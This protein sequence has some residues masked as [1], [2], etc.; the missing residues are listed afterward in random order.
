MPLALNTFV[1]NS[2]PPPPI[3]IHL[4]DFF[5]FNFY[6]FL[7]PINLYVKTRY[8]HNDN[9]EQLTKFNILS[10]NRN[11]TV[12]TYDKGTFTLSELLCKMF[13]IYKC[14]ENFMSSFKLISSGKEILCV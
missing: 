4:F 13:N 12:C 5:H 10:D 11:C 9:L 1:S 2:P 6:F 7:I 3:I 14:L 8:L